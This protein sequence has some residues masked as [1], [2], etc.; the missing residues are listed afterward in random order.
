MLPA[1][2]HVHELAARVDAD[3]RSAVAWQRLAFGHRR[4]RLNHFKLTRRHIHFD[5]VHRHVEFAVDVGDGVLR[6]DVNVA[7]AATARHLDERGVVRAEFAVRRDFVNDHL[8][9]A[10]IADEAE[11]A[12]GIERGAVRVRGRLTRFVATVALVLHETNCVAEAAIV[13]DRE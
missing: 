9:E 11:L 2:R 1:I 10:E 13:L 7:W 5:D 4:E 6:V 8:V 3:F 12:A